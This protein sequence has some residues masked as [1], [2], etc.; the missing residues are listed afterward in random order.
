MKQ[1]VYYTTLAFLIFSTGR[2]S[3]QNTA[4]VTGTILDKMLDAPI[5][6]VEIRIKSTPYATISDRNGNF[7]I[8]NIPPGEYEIIFSHIGYEKLKIGVLLAAGDLRRMDVVMEPKTKVL[9]EVEIHSKRFEEAPYPIEHI[10]KPVIR[11]STHKDI[12]DFLREVPNLSGVRKGGSG[13]DPVVRGFKFKQ[14]A[15]VVDG[16]TKIEGGCPNRMDPAVSHISIMDVENMEIYKGPFALRY[17]PNFGGLINLQTA[18]PVPY[19]EYQMHVTAIKGF[20]SNGNGNTEHLSINGGNDRV[21]YLLSGNHRKFEDYT[22]GNGQ[23]VN[24][25]F[26]KYNYKVQLG[27]KPFVDHRLLVSYDR[28]YGR[29]MD[30]PALPMDERSDDTEIYQF[31]YD[32]DNISEKFRRIKIQLYNSDVHHIM[33]NKQRPF[34]DTVIAVSDIRAE[35]MGGRLEATFDLF[36]NDLFLGVDFEQIDKNGERVKNFIL[37]P[38]LPVK[39]EMLW[40]NAGITNAGFYAL[41]ESKRKDY[42]LNI[43]GRVDMNSANSGKLLLE[44]MM[45]KPVY[46]NDDTD[47]RHFNYS[48]SAGIFYTLSK[49]IDI[50]FSVGRAMRSPDMTERFIVLLPIGYD[51]Y[52]YLGNPQLDPEINNEAD[53]KIGYRTKNLGLLQVGGFFSYVQDFITGREVP[54]AVVKPQSKDVVGVKEFYNADHVYLY[55]YEFGWYSPDWSGLNVSVTGAVTI[56]VNPESIKYIIENGEVV[57]QETVENDPLPEIPPFESN[58]KVKYS[59]FNRR[60]IPEAG[61]RLVASQ[62]KVSQAFYERET[63]GFVLADFR[64]SYEFSKELIIHAGVKNIFDKAYYE[65]LNR[66]IIGSN[67]PLYEPGRSFF[68]NMTVNL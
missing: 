48:L 22:A 14:V 20:E 4:V 60:L 7:E 38:N 28:S 34:S 57:G 18:R 15:V 45:G 36:N 53:L 9:K 40:N 50:G 59:M 30:F 61:V 62:N 47:S 42:T 8:T 43:S 21:Y 37:Q 29:N 58:I 25:G 44:N 39:T 5:E 54:P 27:A 13:V 67:A 2:L 10:S 11:R 31:E 64:L 46:E 41:W 33:D 23:R 17:G 1:F 24:A 32:I 26:T 35:N 6:D 65:H 12:G 49:N 3:A 51:N 52:D 19:P 16:A 55:G 56:G 66:R 63:P 68:I